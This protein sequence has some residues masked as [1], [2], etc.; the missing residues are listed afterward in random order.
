MWIVQD[1]DDCL[2]DGYATS[3]VFV[4]LEVFRQCE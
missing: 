2:V 4:S 1:Q 3:F